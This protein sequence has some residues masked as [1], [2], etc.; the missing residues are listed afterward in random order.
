[1]GLKQDVVSNLAAKQLVD[2]LVPA[3][4]P[5][6][7]VD[8][9]LENQASCPEDGIDAPPQRADHRPDPSPLDE[10]AAR[11]WLPLTPVLR[12]RLS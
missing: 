8:F 6:G 1:V 10:P 9:S 12:P 7:D 4:I 3:N 11:T 5:Q 2:R